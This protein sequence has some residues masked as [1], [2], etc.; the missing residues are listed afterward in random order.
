[1]ECLLCAPRVVQKIRLNKQVQL[2]NK[3]EEN[4][5]HKQ[6]NA[7]HSHL[8]LHDKSAKHQRKSNENHGRNGDLH[9]N[10]E[11]EMENAHVE[12]KG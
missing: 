2:K 6:P 5:S 1:M 12:N 8:F 10:A 9:T 11:G 7:V 3:A 4:Q